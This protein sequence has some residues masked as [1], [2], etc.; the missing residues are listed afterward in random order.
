MRARETADLAAVR[1]EQ[2]SLLQA[3]YKNFR[4]FAEDIMVELGFVLTEIQADI[5]DYIAHGGKY[6]MVQAQRSQ[7]KT[8]IAACFAVWSLIHSPAHRVLIVSAGGKQAGDI[9]VLIVRI[10]STVPVLECMQPDKLAGDRTSTDEFDIHH[11]LKGLDKSPSIACMGIEA[12]MQGKRADLLIA[13]DVESSKNGST[14]TQRARILHLTRDFTSINTSG[15]IIWLGTPQTI[16]S[17]YNSLPARG[18]K[19]RIWPGR[20]PTQAQLANYKTHLAP[21]LLSRIQ[22]DPSLQEGGGMFGDQGKP[23]DSMILGEESL[24]AKELDQGEAYF[25]LQHML[26]TSLMDALRHPLSTEKLVVM[27]FSGNAFPLSVVRGMTQ[28]RIQEHV[29]S[30]APFRT[31][32]PHSIGTDMAPLQKRWAYIDPAGG[33]ANADETAWAIGGA[34]NSSIFLESCGGIAGGYDTAKLEFL[35]NLLAE[36]KVDG[37]TI[38]KNMG[39]GAFAAIFTPILRQ[40]WACQIEE[41]LVSGQKERRIANTLGP[42]IGRGSLIVSEAVV[43]EDDRLTAKY[44]AALRSSYSLFYQM[45]NMTEERDSLVHDD[46]LDALEGL[47]RTFQDALVTDNEKTI[48]RRRERA[49]AEMMKDP[50][51]YGRRPPSKTYGSLLRHRRR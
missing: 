41:D 14:S 27:R 3:H 31:M 50:L 28:D 13:D 33:G 5:G 47:C 19:I 38:E 43:A 30:T 42:I 20:Y 40:K 44:S 4:S 6:I 12:S 35:A 32:A 26:N 49:H 29:S 51:G 36:H 34:L 18:V 2:L 9:S 11:S 10:I 39:Y 23:I 37:V 46:R 24:Q 45:N 16:E 22:A 48:E 25:Q 21:L 8:S 17:I 1:W 15:R 7:A